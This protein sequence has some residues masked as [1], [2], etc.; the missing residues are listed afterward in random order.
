MWSSLAGTLT[1]PGTG[2]YQFDHVIFNDGDAYNPA[3]GVFTA[4]YD[5]VYVFATQLFTQAEERAMN[6]IVVNGNSASRMALDAASQ[7]S[8]S[9]AEREQSVV[10]TVNVKL[11][12]G[13]TVWV[14][15]GYGHPVPL[16][17]YGK[18]HSLFTGALL[19]AY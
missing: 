10:T 8:S 11:V 12:Q 14:Q 6:D 2:P 9:S 16:G 19:Y 15:N 5:G 1:A 7:G 4:P 13:D 3:L 17:I 18:Y